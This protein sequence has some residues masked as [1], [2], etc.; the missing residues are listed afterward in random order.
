MAGKEFME[1]VKVF[2]T[3]DSLNVSSRVTKFIR[4]DM[5]YVKASHLFIQFGNNPVKFVCFYKKKPP[6]F[7]H[8]FG[9]KIRK[10]FK[11]IV[12]GNTKC[13][14]NYVKMYRKVDSE[15]KQKVQEFGKSVRTRL[16]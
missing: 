7:V 10:N 1:K 2:K 14:V 11:C 15:Y 9:W 16:R 8:S 5:S 4:F 13:P 3:D 12:F 6:R